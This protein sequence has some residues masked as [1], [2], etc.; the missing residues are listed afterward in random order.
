MFHNHHARD[1]P[2]VD[3]CTMSTIKEGSRRARPGAS[4][5]APPPVSEHARPVVVRLM[6]AL[7]ELWHAPVP[8]GEQRHFDGMLYRM[9]MM[10]SSGTFRIY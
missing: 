5:V 10:R 1:E 9:S 7:E 8:S 3:N 6:A 4:V 2:F